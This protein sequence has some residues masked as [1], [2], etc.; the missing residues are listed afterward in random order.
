MPWGAAGRR[1]ELRQGGVSEPSALHGRIKENLWARPGARAKP[2]ANPR[3]PAL[4][5]AAPEVWLLAQGQEAGLNAT[6]GRAGQWADSVAALIPIHTVLPLFMRAGGGSRRGGRLFM[7]AL[8][9]SLFPLP[10]LCCLLFLQSAF[11]SGFNS[12]QTLP[13]GFFTWGPQHTRAW[14]QFPEISRTPRTQK[15]DPFP[16]LSPLSPGCSSALFCTPDTKL[17]GQGG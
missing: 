12:L 1:Q 13:N 7:L 9:P 5:A 6:A 4:P 2:R 14:H 15:G 17:G 8:K 11:H 10:P 3:L 16:T